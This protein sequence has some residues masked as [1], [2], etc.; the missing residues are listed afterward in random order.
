MQ[1]ASLLLKT[2]TPKIPDGGRIVLIGS[3]VAQGARDK[4]M[5]A[6]SK[7]AYLGLARSVAIELADRAMTRQR[8]FTRCDSSTHMLSDPRPAWNN[9]RPAAVWAVDTARRNCRD[10]AFFII[11][12]GRIDYRTK[13]RRLWRRFV[14]A[15]DNSD[16]D[17]SQPE[18]L[19]I[20]DDLTGA[21]DAAVPLI[22]PATRLWWRSPWP[23]CRQP[24]NPVQP[25]WR[26]PPNPG[27]HDQPR[28]LRQVQKCC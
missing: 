14:I 27:N 1:A 25:W 8:R 24:Y 6:A 2:M 15:P 18:L 28:P 26:S 16:P 5:Y 3:R 22:L 9:A 4:S 23:L 13:H 17:M 20:A 7:A 11:R 10:G 19:I 12:R 21:L